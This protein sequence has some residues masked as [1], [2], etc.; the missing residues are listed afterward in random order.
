VSVAIAPSSVASRLLRRH[1]DNML[2]RVTD[3]LLVI[4]LLVVADPRDAAACPSGVGEDAGRFEWVGES[5]R[6]V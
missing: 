2:M 4:R 1:L 3:L 5:D 6:H